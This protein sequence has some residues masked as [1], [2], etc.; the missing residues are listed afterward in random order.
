MMRASAAVGLPPPNTRPAM[1]EGCLPLS[2]GVGGFD[3][4]FPPLDLLTI[5][6]SMIDGFVIFL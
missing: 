5:F 1:D 4:G 3:G 2:R 6:Y